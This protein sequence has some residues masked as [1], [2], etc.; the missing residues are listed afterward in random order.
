MGCEEFIALTSDSVDGLLTAE[1]QRRYDA[2]GESCASCARYRRVLSRGLKVV[3]ELPEIQPSPDFALRLHKQL[4]A[5]DEEM[6]TRHRSVTSGVGVVFAVSALVAL[7]AW[8]PLLLQRTSAAPAI[9]AET[10]PAIET[11]STEPPAGG[12]QPSFDLWYG[13]NVTARADLPEA[14]AMP[15]PYSPLIVE[16]PDVGVRRVMTTYLG[17]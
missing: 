3:A 13:A 15:G 14:S 8:A 2:H 5:V 10:P 9:V 16:P 6:L 1:E 17:Q 7:A 4:R 11:I 12:P